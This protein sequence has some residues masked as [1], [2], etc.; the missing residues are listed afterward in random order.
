MSNGIDQLKSRGRRGAGR[1]MPTPRHKPRQEQVDITSTPH[2]AEPTTNGPVE[3][4]APP[5]ASAPTAP[6]SETT[7]RVSP[8][9]EIR[10][11]ATSAAAHATPSPPPA[12]G[13]DHTTPPRPAAGT[14]SARKVGPTTMY[15]DAETDDWLEDVLAVGRRGTPKVSS[16]SAIARLAIRELAKRMTI[17]QVVDELRRGAATG[18]NQAGRPKL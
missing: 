2:E 6:T 8:E 5:K 9:V 16:K 11:N 1:P 4:G 15:F 18:T 14:T 13:K 12:H 7:A 17:E 3:T 10:S